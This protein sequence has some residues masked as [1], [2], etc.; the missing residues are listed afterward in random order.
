MAFL[1]DSR[2]FAEPDRLDLVAWH[3]NLA[4]SADHF[5]WREIWRSIDFSEASRG[6]LQ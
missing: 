6:L 5:F 1:I 3:Y 4:V 2:I